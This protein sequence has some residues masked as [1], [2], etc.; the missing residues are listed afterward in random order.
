MANKIG[1]TADGLRI[2]PHRVRRLLVLRFASVAA[3]ER[4][5]AD[6]SRLDGVDVSRDGAAVY[7]AGP[8]A[9]LR[10]IAHAH[11]PR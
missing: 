2:R 7:V 10:E 8:A 1:R 9:V 3:A 4:W 11:A 6:A 5:A